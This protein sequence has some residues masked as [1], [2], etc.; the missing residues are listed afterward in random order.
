[1]FLNVLSWRSWLVI[2]RGQV[3]LGTFPVVYGFV[4][5]LHQNSAGPA[6][7]GGPCLQRGRL[8]KGD[9]CA[10]QMQVTQFPQSTLKPIPCLC[11]F[12][13][14]EGETRTTLGISVPQRGC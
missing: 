4:Y 6:A 10:L 9:L 3:R 14:V 11:F 2:S 5:F 7:A 13:K 8:Q 1:M 12:G